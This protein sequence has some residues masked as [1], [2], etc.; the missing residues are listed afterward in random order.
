MSISIPN[1]GQQN[2]SALVTQLGTTKDSAEIRTKLNGA[3]TGTE[4][5]V[6]EKGSN[7][8]GFGAAKREKHQEAARVDI[9]SALFNQFGPEIG[10]KVLNNMSGF[11][12]GG[13]KVTVADARNVLANANATVVAARKAEVGSHINL[14]DIQNHPQVSTLFSAFVR[15]EYSG[16]NYDFVQ[17]VRSYR[18]IPADANGATYKI[19]AAKALIAQFGAGGAQ[20]VN[21][22]S[23]EKLSQIVDDNYNNLSEAQKNTLFDTAEATIIKLAKQ[24]TARRFAVSDAALNY[25]SNG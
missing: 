13:G 8:F 25:I 17:S 10:N 2:L 3:N 12:Q 5:Y 7:I 24:D 1:A 4:L 21:L 23:N 15:R 16:E 19:D 14:F 20:M 6:K 18:A 9:T 22:P 11:F